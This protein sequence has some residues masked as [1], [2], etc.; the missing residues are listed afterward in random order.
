MSALPGH[1]DVNL[2]RYRQSIVDLDTE[3]PYGA[4][5]LRVAEQKLHCS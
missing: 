4:F 2:I 1:S 3:I 5:D